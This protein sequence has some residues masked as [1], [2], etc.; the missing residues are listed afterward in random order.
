MNSQE[1]QRIRSIVQQKR[2]KYERTERTKRIITLTKSSSKNPKFG[3]CYY[4]GKVI[5][6]LLHQPPFLL[7]QL[8]ESETNDAKEFCQNIR[9]YNATYVFTS[10]GALLPE[11]N[12]E[13]VYAQLYIYDSDIAYQM[14]IGHNTNLLPQTMQNIQTV[15]QNNYLL[16][17]DLS[18]Y[19]HYNSVNDK[20]HYNL[21]LTNKIAVILLD[22]RS[23][24]EA[25]HDIVIRL[26]ELCQLL[27]DA[28]GQL[29]NNQN[30]TPH[31]T[32]IDF[33]PFAVTEQNKL[34][35][36]R[37]NQNILCADVY[38]GLTDIASEIVNSEIDLN[39]LGR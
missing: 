15:L 33:F 17:T 22:D 2:R 10:L 1:L 16:N 9:Q 8:F 12:I 38:Q 31:L 4:N 34:R 26:Q 14:R 18:V 35:Y 37:M 20:Y 30:N 13:P 23:L 21:L 39:N 6:P 3:K 27:L 11:E 29:Y 7:K 24:P 25:I 5:F 32:Q 28:K 19:L 36:L